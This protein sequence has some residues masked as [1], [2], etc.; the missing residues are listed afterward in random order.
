M[1]LDTLLNTLPNLTLRDRKLIERAY[2]KAEEKHAP[3]TRQSGEPYFTHC[4]AVAHIL[5]DMK[6]DA[7]AIAAGNAQDAVQITERI[8]DLVETE[9]R[10]VTEKQNV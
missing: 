5:A 6:L 4:V 8:M 2:H 7:E 9:I 3:Q 1:D 10:Q